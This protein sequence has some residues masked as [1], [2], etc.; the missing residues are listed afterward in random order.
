MKTRL[1]IL[2]IAILSLQGYASAGE[3]ARNGIYIAVEDN[4]LFVLT[5]DPRTKTGDLRYQHDLLCQYH[6]Q[7]DGS[8]RPD[9]TLQIQRTQENKLTSANTT[10][11]VETTTGPDGTSQQL[12]Q[13][14]Q[15]L[16]GMPPNA[17]A[18]IHRVFTL[19]HALDAK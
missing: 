5:L 4:L 19:I 11:N 7:A 18:K 10:I 6:R 1:S 9:S 14:E 2:I 16:V 13:T 12:I 15:L 17:R 8:W 3:P